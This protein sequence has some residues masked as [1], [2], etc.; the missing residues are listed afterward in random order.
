MKYKDGSGGYNGC[1][2]LQNMEDSLDWRKYDLLKK[3]RGASGHEGLLTTVKLLEQVYT[4]PAFPVEA[5]T[6]N[7]SMQ[8]KGMSRADLWAFAAILATEIGLQQR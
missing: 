4:E 1:L 2:N 3:D 6:L 5:P 7:M 8:D